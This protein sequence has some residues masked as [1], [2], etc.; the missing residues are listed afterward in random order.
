M[1]MVNWVVIAGAR[2]GI[3]QFAVEKLKK[4]KELIDDERY[5]AAKAYV[6]TTLSVLLEDKTV[7]EVM[8]I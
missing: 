4:I 5:F 7:I 2:A 8:K 3:L 1:K 6:D